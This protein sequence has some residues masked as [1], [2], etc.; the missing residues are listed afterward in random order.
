MTGAAGFIGGH[1]VPELKAAGYD[2]VGID[3]PDGDLTER[4]EAWAVLDKH[5]PDV[6]FHLA[7][8]VG[9][10][11]CEDDLGHTL[12]SNVIATTYVAQWCARNEVHLVHTSTSEV[13]GE[14]G[15]TVCDE[16][17]PLIAEPTGI[18]AQ[19]KRYSEEMVRSYGPPGA[20][21]VRP[22]MPYGPGAPPGQGRRALDNFLWLAEN[23]QP[24]E[25]HRGAARSWCWIGDTVRGFRYVLERGGPGAYNV[26]RDDAELSMLDLAKHA[27]ELTGAPFDLIEEVD[28]PARQTVVKRLSTERL[29]KLGWSPTVELGE[30]L[31]SVLDWV[32]Q[33]PYETVL[34]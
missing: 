18:Y 4:R 16:T 9:R 8:Q 19:S 22:S 23:R 26:G 7:A 21:I 32:R 2:V 1:L 34:V 33:F 13:Y 10:L 27:C 5:H 31:P 17:M 29:R 15:D 30:G 28:A 20:Q 6:V 11:F 3:K 12:R 14:H 25:V 24:I